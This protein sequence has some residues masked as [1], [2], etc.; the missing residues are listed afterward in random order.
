VLNVLWDRILRQA[1]YKD[2]DEVEN[3]VNQLMSF[4]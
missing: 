2:K 1:N 4:T 3:V